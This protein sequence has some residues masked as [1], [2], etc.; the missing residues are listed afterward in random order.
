MTNLSEEEILAAF[1]S[2][3]SETLGMAAWA[4]GE[5]RFK[6]A[7]EI[8]QGLIDRKEEVRVFVNGRS[9]EKKLGEWAKGAIAKIK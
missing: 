1:N 9:Q 6:S 8:L 4:S 5:T 2:E 3:D 7:L